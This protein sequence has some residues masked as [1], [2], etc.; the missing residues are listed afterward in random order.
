M[1]LRWQLGAGTSEKKMKNK[2]VEVLHVI[3][4]VRLFSFGKT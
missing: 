2:N 3:V 1:D 4:A